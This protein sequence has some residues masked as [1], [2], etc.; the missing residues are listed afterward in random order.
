[1]SDNLTQVEIIEN[2][3]MTKH[4]AQEKPIIKQL[5]PKNQIESTQLARFESEKTQRVQTETKASTFGQ[6]TNQNSQ[7]THETK[8]SLQNQKIQKNSAQNQPKDTD[9]DLPEFTRLTNSRVAQYEASK[10]SIE[11]PSDI[12]N[13]SATNLNTDATTYYSF[14]NRVEELI[15]VRWVERLDSYWNRIPLSF[16]KDNLYG[17]NWITQIEVI[18]NAN[19]E[20]YSSTILKSCGYQPFDEATIFA[21]KNAR[22][23]PNVPRAKVEPDGFV[24][25]KYS[26][27]LHIGSYR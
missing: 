13:A 11:L 10:I 21:F 7:P 16:K 4:S 6:T 23:F 3:P 24:R 18:L 20:Y 27:G 1:M 8:K 5:D 25:L 19:G 17:R 26:F 15:Y 22:Y 9:E 12:Q 14:Y 2:K